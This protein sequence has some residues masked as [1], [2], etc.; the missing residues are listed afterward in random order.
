MFDFGIYFLNA[1]YASESIEL[2][3]L[4]VYMVR[5]RNLIIVR[6]R[7]PSVSQVEEAVVEVRPGQLAVAGGE[8]G[9]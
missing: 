5:V 4:Y 6:Y 9:G 7:S 3:V 1:A 8:H 2:V